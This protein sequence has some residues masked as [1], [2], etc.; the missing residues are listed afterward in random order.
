[1]GGIIDESRRFDQ[2]LRGQAAPIGAGTPDRAK[3]GHD[4]AFAEFGGIQRRGK[5][6]RAAAQNHQVIMLLS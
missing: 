2:V 1:M 5:G 3:F 4:G 6:R